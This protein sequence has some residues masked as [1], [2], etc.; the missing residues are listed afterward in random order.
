MRQ[1]TKTRRLRRRRPSCLDGSL[2]RVV[3]TA[4]L[5][6][7][8]FVLLIIGFSGTAE[9]FA[10]PGPLGWLYIATVIVAA[11]VALIWLFCSEDK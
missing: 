11:T 2:D 7:V 5:L 6:A 9:H 3:I 10:L 4:V 1:C 8:T